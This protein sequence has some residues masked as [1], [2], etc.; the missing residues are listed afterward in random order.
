[1]ALFLATDL[2]PDPLPMDVDEAITVE[3]WPLATLM[4]MA[5]DGRLEDGKSVVT[6]LRVAKEIG[7]G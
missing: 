7:Y 2:S 4:E 5:L 3:A 1:M 6:V